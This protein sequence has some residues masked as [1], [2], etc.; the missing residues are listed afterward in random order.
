MNSSI[1]PILLIGA[2]RLGQALIQ[3]WRRSNAFPM[4]DLMIREPNRSPE[5][6]AVA[7]E[8]ARLNPPDEALSAVKTVVI[9]VKPQAW[10]D[11]APAYDA[12]LAKDAVVLS[13][14]AGARLAD[15]ARGLGD[16]KI[17]RIV[18]T[19][20]VAAARGVASIFAPDPL[21]KARAEA[22]F[23]PIATTVGLTD[24]ALIDAAV[25]VSGSGVAY[26]YAFVQALEAAG[27]A[28]GLSG[29]TAE[30]LAR[31]TV[32]SA[33]ALLE[34]TG[35]E[36]QTLIEQVASPGGTTRAGLAVL[37]QDNALSRL[38]QD[39]VAAAVARARELGG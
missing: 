13:V 8:G 27:K 12:A 15:L 38:M 24:E 32:I 21:S 33:A 6:E 11:L 23:G 18:P 4:T 25:G 19:T 29:E 10:P 3:G 28:A 7:V 37:N 22:L 2:G 30:T 14:M 26:V 20:G 17:A 16:R 1:A 34:D 39:T 35:A 9:C 5:A 31:A 36:P